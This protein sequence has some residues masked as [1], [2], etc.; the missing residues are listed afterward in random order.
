MKKSRVRKYKAINLL[1]Y[2][3]EWFALYKVGLSLP[4]EQRSCYLNAV[5]NCLLFALEFYL[6]ALL[7]LFDKK[8]EKEDELKKLDHNFK[9]MIKELKKSKEKNIISLVRKIE[10]E[11]GYLIKINPIEL[12]YPPLHSLISH[13]TEINPKLKP[14]FGE[15]RSLIIVKTRS[16]IRKKR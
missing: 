4:Y 5:H 10:K 12:R 8:Y 2:A 15:I 1:S 3:E 16:S 11:I 13:Q 14:I 6:K 7:A 9:Q